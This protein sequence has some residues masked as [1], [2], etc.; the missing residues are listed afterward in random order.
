MISMCSYGIANWRHWRWL[1]K[2]LT[3]ILFLINVLLKM[4]FSLHLK[5]KPWCDI[6]LRNPFLQKKI[7]ESTFVYQYVDCVNV[8]SL[9]FNANIIVL[10]SFVFWLLYCLS[11]HLQ[12]LI[13]PSLWY[14]QTFLKFICSY[15]KH[16]PSHSEIYN[17]ILPKI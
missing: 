17:C 11:L 9:V 16:F 10:F 4:N 5:S 3:K 1:G 6:D 8:S 13:N 15:I 7:K 12:L 2:S 14:L